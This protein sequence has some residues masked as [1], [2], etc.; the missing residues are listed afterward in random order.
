[1]VL[2]VVLAAAVVSAPPQAAPQE[3]PTINAAVL[4]KYFEPKSLTRLEWELMEF[5]TFWQGSFEGSSDYITSNPVLFD[6]K[7]MRFVTT[8]RVSEKRDSSDPEPFF[9]L[10][11]PRRE[12]LLQRGINYLKDLL[13]QKFPEV[14]A[15]PSLLSVQFKFHSSGG[16]SSTVARYENGTLILSE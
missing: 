5:N 8:F 4:K 10:P 3:S 15:N 14:N 9:R 12:A 13:A 7:A 1:M 11:R 6:F 2:A 16:G